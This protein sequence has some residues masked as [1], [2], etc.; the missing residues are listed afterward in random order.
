MRRASSWSGSEN[1]R[2]EQGVCLP[3]TVAPNTTPR[4]LVPAGSKCAVSRISKLD[5]QPYTTVQDIGFE[6]FERFEQG[7]SGNFY[8]FRFEGWLMLVRWD[9][10][11]HR[12]NK[13]H[14]RSGKDL[15]DMAQHLRAIQQES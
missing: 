6:R 3:P 8:E 11:R 10:V 2:R 4:F 7:E 13:Y 9:L 5:W 15:G 1:R 14:Q 12:S